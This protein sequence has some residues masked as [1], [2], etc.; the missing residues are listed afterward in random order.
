MNTQEI[1]AMQ[2]QYV[3]PTHAPGLALVRGEGCK[4][5][6]ADGKKYLDFLG[7]LA[8]ISVGHGHPKLAKAIGDQAAKLMHVSNL[9][10]NENQPMLAKKIVEKFGEG[11]V[12]FCNSGAEANEGLI[13]LARYWGHAAGKYEIISMRNSFHGRT[14]ATLTATGQFKVQK[15]FDPLPGGFVYANFNDIKSVREAIT[16]RTVAIITEVIQ[17]EGGVL[18]ADPEFMRQL[19]ALCDE[20]NILLLIDEVQTGIGRTGNWFGFQGY[21]VKPDAISLAKGLGGGFPIGAIVASAKYQDTFSVGSHATTFGGTPLACAAGL[22]VIQIM[23]EENLIENSRKRGTQLKAGLEQIAAKYPWIKS[24]RGAGL[25]VGM[26]L[27]QPAKE[28]EKLLT[29]K[30]LLTIATADKVIRFLPP[31][32]VSE[33]EV[34]AALAIVGSAC[35]EFKPAA[36]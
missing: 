14:M 16:E 22:A 24:V 27:D 10:Y 18:P 35:A 30:G 32:T 19:R 25:I 17:A 29:A 2:K 6:D 8:V 34:N 9:F 1:I 11:K 13:K 7:G 12:F 36:A 4:V 33:S 28:L 3:M 5:W 26:V 21:G 20:K 31:L 15:G 23:D